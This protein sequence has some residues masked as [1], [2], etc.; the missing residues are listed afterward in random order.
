MSTDYHRWKMRNLRS[1]SRHEITLGYCLERDGDVEFRDKLKSGYKKI[2]YNYFAHLIIL[3]LH[4][5]E[6]NWIYEEY[7]IRFGG[8]KLDF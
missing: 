3:T 2:Y 4:P 6:Q 8:K 1:P 7:R 5:V